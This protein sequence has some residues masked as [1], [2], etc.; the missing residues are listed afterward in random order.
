[1]WVGFLQISQPSDTGWFLP[2]NIRKLLGATPLEFLDEQEPCG[3]CKNVAGENGLWAR[4]ASISDMI[5]QKRTYA[6]C[7]AP[8]VP[9]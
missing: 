9:H 4:C 3:G 2:C 5:V 6:Y 8:H 1:M 7:T